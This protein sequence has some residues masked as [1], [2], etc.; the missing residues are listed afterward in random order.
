LRATRGRRDG[1]E[2]V[3]VPDTGTLDD[4]WAAVSKALNIP[5]ERMA[6]SKDPK[7]VS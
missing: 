5:Q 2:R 7:L 3:Q 1:L 4:M 6:L